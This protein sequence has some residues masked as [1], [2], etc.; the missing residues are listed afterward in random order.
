VE[1]LAE[2]VDWLDSLVIERKKWIW[3]LLLRLSAKRIAINASQMVY[4]S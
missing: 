4:A 2:F 1:G 3:F